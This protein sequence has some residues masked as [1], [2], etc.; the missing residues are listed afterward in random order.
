MTRDGQPRHH[1]E[2]VARV[3]L[4][5]G[6]GPEHAAAELLRGRGDERGGADR[7]LLA[8]PLERDAARSDSFDPIIDEGDTRYAKFAAGVPQ[9]PEGAASSP[10]VQGKL[11][12]ALSQSYL[13]DPPPAEIRF[14]VNPFVDLVLARGDRR[15][16]GAMFAI[17]PTPEGRRRRVSD[18]Y[19]ARLARELNRAQ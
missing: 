15:V 19:G 16:G 8:R 11:I 4:G 10:S 7:E 1:P 2:P 12:A 17:W 14:N 3:L 13:K 6:R 9:T 18:V 5:G